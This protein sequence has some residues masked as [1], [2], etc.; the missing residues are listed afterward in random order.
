MAGSV[1][2]RIR[3]P[4]VAGILQI[5]FIVLFAVFARYDESALPGGTDDEAGNKN[6]YATFQ[7]V[8]VMMFVGFGFLMT[9]LKRYGYSSVGI[10]F[11]IAALCLQWA[12]LVRG[13][14]HLEDD[15]TFTVKLGE[16]LTADFATATVLIS[17]GACLG[18]TTPTQ[19]IFMALI[20]IVLAQVNEK[21]GLS[22]LKVTDAGE[23]MFVHIFG[24]YFGMAC[25]RALARNDIDA[26]D[27]EG[28][29]YY[30]DMF[31]MIGTIF[32][33][34]YW[35]SFN[36]GA[37]TGVE[38]NRAFIN[39]Y[40]SLAA[41]CVFTFVF[42]MLVDGEFNMVHIQNATLAGGVAIGTAADLLVKPYGALV[43][44][45]VAA[46]V[47][48]IGYK[49]ITPFLSSKLKIHDTCGVHNLH[50]MPGVLAALIGA[51]AAWCAT[52]EQYGE[53]LFAKF[54]ARVPSEVE[55]DHFNSLISDNVTNFDS[56]KAIT[57]ENAGDD[58]TAADQA[59]YQL[60]A[61]GVTLAIA[62]VGGALTGNFFINKFS[63]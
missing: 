1:G 47:S 48:V 49:W 38:Q 16:M 43:V 60:A 8:H 39:T 29:T 32:L 61:L 14:L 31:A 3:F 25:A 53:T 4:L 63:F 6:Q 26:N 33:W 28:A 42:S 20:E 37:L 34:L 59:L 45:S 23:S 2:N 46:L 62:I 27:G 52:G 12:T 7:D 55:N 24:A 36:G 17:F 58:R 50:G 11:M 9:F 57:E 44:G 54:P 10:N 35:P 56:L 22:Y 18:K 51:L 19:L 41:C 13:F 30:S 5:V 15:K 21:I 40:F